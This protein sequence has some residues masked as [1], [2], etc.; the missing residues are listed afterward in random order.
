MATERKWR[1]AIKCINLIQVI[2]DDCG[3]SIMLETW[4]EAAK[5]DWAAPIDGAFQRC[6]KCTRKYVDGLY[7]EA[8]LAQI[9]EQCPLRNPVAADGDAQD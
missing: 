6:P 3:T 1:M 8:K 7:R 2:C 4:Q 5:L 9:V